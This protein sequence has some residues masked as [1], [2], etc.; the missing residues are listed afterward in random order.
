LDVA[1]LADL[2]TQGA[3]CFKAIAS[4]TWIR[5]AGGARAEAA[6]LARASPRITLASATPMDAAKR[7][8][9]GEERGR[10]REEHTERGGVAT[11]QKIQ[12]TFRSTEHDP[13]RGTFADSKTDVLFAFSPFHFVTQTAAWA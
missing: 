1:A 4:S 6:A 7:R 12:T 9:M 5:D 11:C 8:W 10:V 3:V 2:L 13:Y